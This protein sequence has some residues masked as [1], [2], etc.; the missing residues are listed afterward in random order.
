MIVAPLPVG[1]L[2]VVMELGELDVF[3][4]VLGSIHPIRLILMIIPFMIVIVLFV[5]VLAICFVI[6][7]EQR[8]RRNRYRDYKGGAQQGRIPETG[9]D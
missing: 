2:V 8:Y 3:A 5:V 4:M 1:L 6:I 9:H 7:G